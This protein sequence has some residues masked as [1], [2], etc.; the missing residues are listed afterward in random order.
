MNNYNIQ[1]ADELA[2]KA[3]RKIRNEQRGFRVILEN[4]S[5]F[6]VGKKCEELFGTYGK[7]KKGNPECKQEGEILQTFFIILSET[8]HEFE[9]WAHKKIK[10]ELAEIETDTV[11]KLGKLT[12]VA[13]GIS[14]GLTASS[15]TTTITT[16]ITTPWL[17]I[18]FL[19]SIGLTT[20]TTT[21]SVASIFSVWAATGIG[22]VAGG[23]VFGG[24]LLYK[25]NKAKKNA[26]EYL[27]KLSDTCC[28]NIE[29]MKFEA[30]KEL[31]RRIEKVINSIKDGSAFEIKGVI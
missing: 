24:V 7:D 10:D 5:F 14:A 25:G 16:S 31:N 22:A 23:A 29:K 12:S 11:G 2:K 13:A 9:K 27:D 30:I 28:K 4:T 17:G 3:I 8:R 20:T 26:L 19:G 18:N 15:L 1:E 6:K 21:T